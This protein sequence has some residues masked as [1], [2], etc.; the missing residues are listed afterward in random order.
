M[1][2]SV[3]IFVLLVGLAAF[4]GWTL[5]C[6][7]VLRCVGWANLLRGVVFSLSSFSWCLPMMDFSRIS[8]N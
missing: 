8:R 1:G 5:S 4:A 6:F 7:T 2:L 3:S